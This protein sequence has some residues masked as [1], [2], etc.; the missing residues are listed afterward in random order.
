[1]RH[2]GIVG[3]GIAVCGTGEISVSGGGGVLPPEVE[4]A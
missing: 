3:P 4:V 2:A 1:M